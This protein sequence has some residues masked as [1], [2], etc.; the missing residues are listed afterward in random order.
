MLTIFT[1]NSKTIAALTFCLVTAANHTFERF[2]WKN[3]VLAIFVTGDL[4]CCRAWI[5]LTRKAST[6]FRL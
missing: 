6:A 1:R 3:D 4:T 2:M 5:T